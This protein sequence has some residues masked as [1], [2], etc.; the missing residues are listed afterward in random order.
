LDLVE[1][2]KEQCPYAIIE[3][4]RIRCSASFFKGEKEKHEEN[5]LEKC[6]RCA[7]CQTNVIRK[8]K[9][10]HEAVCAIEKVFC[11][12]YEVGCN[13]IMGRNRREKH[14]QDFQLHH[15]DVLCDSYKNL[16]EVVNSVK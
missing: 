9:G 15:I 6:L 3:C 13:F 11:T 16:K 4:N 7:Y 14:E 12:F 2:H 10:D 1:D 5:C 8:N